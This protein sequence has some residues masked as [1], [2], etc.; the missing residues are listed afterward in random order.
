M[1]DPFHFELAAR[2]EA[3]LLS[4]AAVDDGLRDPDVALAGLIA[5]ARRHLHGCAEEIGSKEVNRD[6]IDQ[7]LK[8]VERAR[9]EGVDTAPAALATARGMHHP[10]LMRFALKLPDPLYVPNRSASS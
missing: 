7:Y 8:A 3:E 10:Q 6:P 4:L 5:N 1:L 2:D 9:M